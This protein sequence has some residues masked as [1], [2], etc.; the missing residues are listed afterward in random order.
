MEFIIGWYQG[1]FL[2]IW[3]WVGIRSILAVER[4]L[5]ISSSI[6]LSLEEADWPPESLKNNG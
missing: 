5:Y 3:F 6:T 1:S 2:G 4:R